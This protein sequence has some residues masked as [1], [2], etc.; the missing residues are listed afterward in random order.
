[1]RLVTKLPSELE[2]DCDGKEV[3]LPHVLCGMR[4]RQA[5]LPCT[6]VWIGQEL[7]SASGRRAE[8]VACRGEVLKEPIDVQK[9]AP[10]HSQALRL[11]SP[12][13]KPREALQA[14]E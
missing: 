3:D 7:V 12:A 8:V 2:G 5:P 13:E 1:L 9:L 10:Y 6:S 11:V 14:K 4:W